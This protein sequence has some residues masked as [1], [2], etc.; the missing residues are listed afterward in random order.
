MAS[1][2]IGALL[3]SNIINKHFERPEYKELVEFD[4]FVETWE[5][6]DFVI[7]IDGKRY[8]VRINREDV[9]E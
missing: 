7:I 8:E 3:L 2:L 4:K 6:Q 1:I 9:K 5:G